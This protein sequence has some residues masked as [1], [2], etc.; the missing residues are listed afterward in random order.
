MK[1]I[2]PLGNII[3]NIFKKQI[4]KEVNT[5]RKKAVLYNKIITLYQCIIIEYYNVWVLTVIKFLGVG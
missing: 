5:F 4:P 1:N 2:I 3:E